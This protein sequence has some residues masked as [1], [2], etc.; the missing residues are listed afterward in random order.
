MENDCFIISII[1]A[2]NY[3]NLIALFCIATREKEIFSFVQNQIHFK[4]SYQIALDVS[5]EH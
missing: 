2:H 3:Q 4:M 1:R 5:R